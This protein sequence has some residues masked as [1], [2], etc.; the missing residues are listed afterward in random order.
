MLF[1]LVTRVKDG[2]S[3][4]FVMDDVPPNGIMALAAELERDGEIKFRQ[5]WQVPGAKPD[6]LPEIG[7]YLLY[8]MGS[9]DA[10]G[11]FSMHDVIREQTPRA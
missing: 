2:D 10:Q 8:A 11:N 4:I 9:T 3:A 6:Y 1:V 5:A 7:F